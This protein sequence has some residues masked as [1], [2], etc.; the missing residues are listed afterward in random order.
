MIPTTFIGCPFIGP[1]RP[2]AIYPVMNTGSRHLPR[3]F[4]G[5][6]ALLLAACGPPEPIR[7]GYLGGL[8]GG[9]SDL[10]I[11]G[12]N[13]VRLAVERHNAQGGVQGRPVELIE[14]DDRQDPQ[15]AAT[16]VHSLL[17]KKVAAIVGPMTSAIAMGIVPLINEAQIVMISPTVSTTALSGRDD[18]FF[19]VIP[20]TQDYVATHADYFYRQLG[21]QSV[22]FIHD[23]TN[24]AFTESWMH[25]FSSAFSAFGGTL[26][27]P[28]SYT[29]GESDNF[30]RIV[31][32]ALASKTNAILLLGNSVD[33]ALLAVL[34]RETAPGI[35]LG[36]AEWGATG[37]LIEL[38]G[39]T[40]DGLSAAQFH[41]PEENNP[42]FL[43]FQEA[44]RSRFYADPPFSSVQG[45]I[46]ADVALQGL[47]QRKPDHSLKHTLLST[48]GFNSLLGTVRF[49]PYG[50]TTG[51]T[52]IV[53]INNGRFVAKPRT[54]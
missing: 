41:D 14:A 28:L 9:V 47:A 1:I 39:R 50:D 16:A 3:W 6:A 32:E 17:A 45:Y 49:D 30:P 15:Q 31:R 22:Q 23:R 19:R 26:A 29:S 27:P 25:S 54:P 44:Y 48:P 20:A 8:S 38:G 35:T 46:A 34:L 52:F 36:T 4:A 51:R 24:S 10:G 53:Q 18:Y 37:R 5:L 7:I 42:E 2:G 13:G 33:V 21:V 12:R 11:G 43:R 40:I